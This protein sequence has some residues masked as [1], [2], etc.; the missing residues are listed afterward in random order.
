MRPAERIHQIDSDDS[1]GYINIGN[2]T[3]RGA[4]F[5]LRRI[6]Q[7]DCKHRCQYFRKNSHTSCTS[8][9]QIKP[10]GETEKILLFRIHVD[11]ALMWKISTLTGT[12]SDLM[13][14]GALDAIGMRGFGNCDF[15][16]EA[17]FARPSTHRLPC[18][19]TEYR[20]P[21]A[22]KISIPPHSATE[23]GLGH[24]DHGPAEKAP[25]PR[26]PRH[27]GYTRKKARDL[28]GLCITG[29]GVHLSA[30]NASSNT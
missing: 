4:N 28:R 20:P 18:Q 24:I 27:A 19:Q 15:G 2:E 7:N 22:R 3:S 23:N 1:R 25:R 17:M 8:L 13:P 10:Q 9:L 30:Q 21:Q 29:G 11:I 26:I 16:H 12:I 6:N 5:G 14:A